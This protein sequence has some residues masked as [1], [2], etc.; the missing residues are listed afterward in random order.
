[1]MTDPS[2]DDYPTTWG[3]VLLCCTYTGMI[4]GRFLAEAL[5]CPPLRALSM[6][7]V[8]VAGF[9]R[10]HPAVFVMPLVL[11]WKLFAIARRRWGNLT[12]RHQALYILGFLIYGACCVLLGANAYV[13]E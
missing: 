9:V 13:S 8:V 5:L 1:M 4:T 6:C 11:L 3:G 12:W 7:C 10:A 2:A